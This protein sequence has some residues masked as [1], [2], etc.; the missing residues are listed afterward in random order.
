MEHLSQRYQERAAYICG[1]SAFQSADLGV[2]NRCFT[3]AE[4]E[5]KAL[6][7]KNDDLTVALEKS[8]QQSTV[9]K[10]QEARLQ[11]DYERVRGI[12]DRI[13]PEIIRAYTQ[14]GSKKQEVNHYSG[15]E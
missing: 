8:Q 3:T 7:K 12:L 5:K 2:G 10:L 11:S 15:L 4:S 9:K 1:F 14:R 13:P 6:K